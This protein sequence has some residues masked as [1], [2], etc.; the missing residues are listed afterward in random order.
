MSAWAG[1]HYFASRHGFPVPGDDSSASTERDAVL[2]WPQGNGW[3]SERLAAPLQ[4]RLHTGRVVQRIDASGASGVIVDAFD[5]GARSVE[6]WHATHCIVALPL[7]IA[8]RV[9]QD[10]PAALIAAAAQS[11]PRTVDR[12]EHPDRRR[13]RRSPRCATELGQRD[14]RIKPRSA[15]S[16]RCTR[17]CSAC[18]VATVLTHYHALLSTEPDCATA[19]RALLERPWSHWRDFVLADL[20]VPHPDLRAKAARIDITRWAHAMSA[21]VPGVRSSAALA[22]LQS[23]PA[24]ARL[25]FAHGD[26]SGYSVFEEAF[27]QGHRAGSAVAQAMRM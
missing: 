10:P 19:R 7:F 23:Q 27:A 20:S 12:V 15:T 2:T 17:A 5:T 9:V 26:L 1:I 8:A 13:A 25:Q 22:A 6:R 14:P 11:A 18:R 21:P 16:M 3:L 4:S 24:N